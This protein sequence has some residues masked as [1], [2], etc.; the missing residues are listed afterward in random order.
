MLVRGT[1]LLLRSISVG[2]GFF[3]VIFIVFS[4][5]LK[6][7]IGGRDVMGCGKMMVLARHVAL[8]VR[9]DA[10]LPI[11]EMSQNKFTGSMALP[12]ASTDRCAAFER[13][14]LGPAT[15]S[16]SSSPFN[17]GRDRA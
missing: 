17:G 10:F 4:H 7:V 6:M 3:M 15:R 14:D 9:H 16:I 1:A 11:S 2:L 13:Q 5:R 8:G 12:F